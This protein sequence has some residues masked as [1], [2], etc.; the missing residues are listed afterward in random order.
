MNESYKNLDKNDIIFLI[1][2]ELEN[3]YFGLNGMIQIHR[4]FPHSVDVLVSQIGSTMCKF[5]CITKNKS[6]LE[7]ISENC[8]VE[9]HKI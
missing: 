6:D 3:K 2:I 1:N 9:V 8:E 7:Y 5:I 4:K